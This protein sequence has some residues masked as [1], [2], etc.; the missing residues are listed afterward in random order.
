V[1]G[2][3]QAPGAADFANVDGTWCRRHDGRLREKERKFVS[4]MASRTVWREPTEKQGK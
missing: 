3:G 1:R 2:R 4:D